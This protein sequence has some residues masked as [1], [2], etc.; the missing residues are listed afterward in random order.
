MPPSSLVSMLDLIYK[1]RLR[2]KVLLVKIYP[3]GQ[4]L[5]ID[6]IWVVHRR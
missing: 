2:T 5:E 3:V 1:G 4:L 6:F